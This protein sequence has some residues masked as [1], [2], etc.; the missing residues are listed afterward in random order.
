MPHK[1][2]DFYVFSGSGNT[3]LLAK[4]MARLFTANEVPTT[5]YPLPGQFALPEEGTLLG[6]AFPT[7][8]FSTYPFVLNFLDHLPDG[9][10]REVF[11]LTTMAGTTGGMPHTIRK[12]LVQ[13]NYR[14]TGYAEIKMPSNYG[15]QQASATMA[16]K[17]II[18]EAVHQ[19]ENFAGQLLAGKRQWPETPTFVAG[20][21]QN[22][23]RKQWSTQ[24]FRK[25]FPL[26]VDE[27]DCI[28]CGLCQKIC[29]AGAIEKLASDFRRIT[30]SCQSCQH[31]S[32]FCPVSAI[33]L[34]G[35]TAPSYKA[36]E[37]EEI[38]N[39][40]AKQPVSKP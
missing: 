38:T 19:A 31:C 10:N 25:F 6:L 1:Q 8:Y 22:F 14:P 36:A 5:L 28:K 33:K 32:A 3:W 15:K 37:Y 34:P 27:N 11:I 39:S 9:R 26:Q 30:G 4:E 35:Q 24:L 20:F 21:L 17:T 40:F 18:E 13:K 7:A 2:I 29:P 23:T 12:L 16:N